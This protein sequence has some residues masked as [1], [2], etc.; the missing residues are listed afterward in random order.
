MCTLNINVYICCTHIQLHEIS[1]YIQ[2]EQTLFSDQNLSGELATNKANKLL[3]IAP[4]PAL[5]SIR[6]LTQFI[7]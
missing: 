5:L 3:T 1:S 2:L 4:V 7:S 6:E